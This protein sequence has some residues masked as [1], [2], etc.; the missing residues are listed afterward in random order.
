MEISC[1]VYFGYTGLLEGLA[2][3]IVVCHHERSRHLHFKHVHQYMSYYTRLVQACRRCRTPGG[4]FN[5]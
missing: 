3:G 5:H 4:G 1:W 2:A